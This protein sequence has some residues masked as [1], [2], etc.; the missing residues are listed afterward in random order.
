MGAAGKVG[1]KLWHLPSSEVQLA[2]KEIA[3][4][5]NK[6]PAVEPQGHDIWLRAK[7]Q[8]A[9]DEMQPDLS[10]EDVEAH[11]AARRSAALRKAEE[12]G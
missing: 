7:V 3:T 4:L 6:E 2:Q 1:L 8:E 10:N 5:Y 11:F 9:L 12:Q